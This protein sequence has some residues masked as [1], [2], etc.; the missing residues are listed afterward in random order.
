MLILDTRSADAI[1]MGGGGHSCYCSVTDV[2]VVWVLTC[3]EGVCTLVPRSVRRGAWLLVV[4][5][6]A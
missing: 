6:A 1:Y 5:A 4:A 2:F 3:M